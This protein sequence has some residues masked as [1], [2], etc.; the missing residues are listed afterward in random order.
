MPQMMPLNWM[1]L[2]FYFTLIFMIFS[3]M[4]YY[5]FTYKM[6][7]T[8]KSNNKLNYNWKW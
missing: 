4:N 3:I 7:Y 5:M 1:L 6:K 8:K 2:L